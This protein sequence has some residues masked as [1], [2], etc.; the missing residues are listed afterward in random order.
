MIRTTEATCEKQQSAAGNALDALEKE[1]IVL[2][3]A[4][5]KLGSHL[6]TVM[7]DSP[8]NSPL[9]DKCSPPPQSQLVRRIYTQADKV[10]GVSMS[11]EDWLS[12]LEI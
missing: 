2:E 3:R 8:A 12:R 5:E 10:R 9:V 4:L 7:T 6:E 11:I 1:V